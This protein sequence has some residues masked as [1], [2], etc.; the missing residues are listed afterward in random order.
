[1]FN[2]FEYSSEKVK[3]ECFIEIVA[4]IL[5]KSDLKKYIQ[6]VLIIVH[7]LETSDAATKTTQLYARWI[8]SIQILSKFKIE[9]TIPILIFKMV[10]QG[11]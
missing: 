11:V 4:Y 3:N 10:V 8:I 7:R 2:S 9:A 6:C 5:R 1:M